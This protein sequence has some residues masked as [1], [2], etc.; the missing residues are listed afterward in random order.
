MYYLKPNCFTS[1]LFV[2]RK[3]DFFR[4]KNAARKAIQVELYLFEGMCKKK[5]IHPLPVSCP[6]CPSCPCWASLS[7]TSAL[8]AFLPIMGQCTA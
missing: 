5:Q 7:D 2:F 1:G 8:R 6:S 3:V 4:H